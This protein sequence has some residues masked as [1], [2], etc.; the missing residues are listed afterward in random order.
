MSVG[1]RHANRRSQHVDA[2]TLNR[3]LETGRETPVPIMKEK[4]VILIAGK[5]FS[6][7]LQSPVSCGVLGH[8]E[9]NQ[10]S[11][12]DLERDKYIKDMEPCRNGD[13][14]IASHNPVSVISQ[15][16]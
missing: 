12:S 11:G 5:R 13:E 3:F 16:G 10:T 7:L 2:P 4:L 15:K 6:K 9:V 1:R 14:E 8:I